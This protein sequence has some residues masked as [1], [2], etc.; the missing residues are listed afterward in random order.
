MSSKDFAEQ[1]ELHC[2]EP[3]LDLRPFVVHIWTQRYHG[4]HDAVQKPLEILSGPNMY[5]F[6]TPDSAFVQ[7]ITPSEFT[8]NP[9]V[10]GVIAG[11]KFRP[12]G[13]YAFLRQSVSSFAAQGSPL[14]TVFPGATESF[15]NTLLGQPDEKIVAMLETLLRGNHPCPD[16]KLDTIA[17]VLDMLQRDASLQTVTAVARA[18]DMSE[19]SLQL[20]F[21]T[22]VGVGLK[23]IM[24]RK[25][26]LSVAQGV[27]AQDYPSW[28]EAAAEFGYNSQS[29]FS[30]EFKRVV[31]LSPSEYMRSGR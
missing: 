20:L 12:G 4:A 22:R 14:A 21:Q 27:R 16:E 28:A 2:Y 11:V 24:A 6:F 5:L 17:K 19:R 18:C 23:W 7:G 10:P 13:F 9:F 26:L 8:Y 15:K 1:F 3:S 25:R 29:H 31:G 30:R